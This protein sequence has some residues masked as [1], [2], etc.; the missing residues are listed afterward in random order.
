MFSL[1][2]TSWVIGKSIKFYFLSISLRKHKILIL[3]LFV[4]F[5]S[6]PKVHFSVKY[7]L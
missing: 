2:I 1:Q 5:I 7:I 6:Y 4:Q 3:K